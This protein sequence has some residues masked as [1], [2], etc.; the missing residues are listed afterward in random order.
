MKIMDSARRYNKG[1]LGYHL[2]SNYAQKE[3]A[4]VYTLGAHKYT[5]Y[6]DEYGN[7]ILGKDISLDE[8]SK[9]KVIDSGEW[10]WTKGQSWTESI[11]S[12]KR[13]IQAWESGEDYDP[14]LGT[15][16]L[17]NAAWGLDTLLDYYKSHPEFDDR[18]KPYFDKKVGLD[19]DGTIVNFSDGF[20]KKAGIKTRNNNWYFSYKWRAMRE[21]LQNDVEF[22]LGLDPLVDATEMKFEASC[23][24]TNRTIPIEISEQW[25]EANN[26]NCAPVYKTDGNKADVLKS[27]GVDFFVD[28]SFTNFAQINNSGVFCYLISRPYNLK[29]NCGHRRIEHLND[30]VNKK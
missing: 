28:D 22:W 11:G 23:Y 15:F 1:K 17:A 2:F 5:L 29:Y 26:F 14:D 27:I 24:V 12:I 13:H 18:I 21:E 30:I 4:K 20:C 10:N 6:E 19:L 9:L 16:H 25:L 7:K 8:A 3:K